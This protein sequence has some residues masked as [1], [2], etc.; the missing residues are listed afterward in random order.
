MI[1][2]SPGKPT[3]WYFA[4]SVARALRPLSAASDGPCELSRARGTQEAG[5]QEDV[6]EPYSRA[7]GVSVA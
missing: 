6:Q 5:E 7:R 1:T 3:G 4:L 2:V